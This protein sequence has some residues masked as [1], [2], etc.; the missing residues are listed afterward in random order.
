MDGGEMEKKA[1][2]FE[3]VR[4]V[5]C[6]EIKR[7][8]AKR[9]AG[10]SGET[11][12]NLYGLAL[13]GGGIRSASFAMG[14]LQ[15]LNAEGALRKIDY[16][17][18]VSGGGYAGS[19]LTW[20]LHRIDPG[21]FPF[22]QKGSGAVSH[23]RENDILGFVRQHGDYLRP[24]KGLDSIS[25]LAV[26]MR[27]S[28]LSLLVYFPL[29]CVLMSLF[30]AWELFEPLKN[31]E[32]LKLIDTW[33]KGI[34]VLKHLAGMGFNALLLVAAAVF[35]GALLIAKAFQHATRLDGDAV[36]CEEPPVK[37]RS[38]K[39]FLYVFVFFTI[40]SMATVNIFLSP[41]KG[42]LWDENF[43]LWFA[44]LLMG[45]FLMMSCIYSLMT[46]VSTIVS[47]YFR[48]V[49]ALRSYLFRLSFQRSMGLVLLLAIV[50][51]VIGLMPDIDGM[52]KKELAA[53]AV[54]GPSAMLGI[55]GAFFRFL[56]EQKSRTG[57]EGLIQKAMVPV[58]FVLMCYGFLQLAFMVSEWATVVRPDGSLDIEH[59]GVIL[60]LGAASLIMGFVVNLNYVSI[61]RMYRD[62][63]A[64]TFLPDKDTV[65]FERC[66]DMQEWRPA[67][68]ANTARLSKMCDA[69]DHGPYHLIN[70]NIVL[71]DS[72]KPVYRGRGGD[73]FLLSPKFCGSGATKWCRTE[74]FM[75]D[76]MTLATAM[77]ISGA[78][79]NPHTGVAGKGPTRSRTASFI[80]TMLNLSLGFW[81]VNPSSR[82]PF[83]VPNYFFPGLK[84][85][86]GFGYDESDV[87]IQLT[88]GG[89]FDNTG[90]YELIR[91]RAK[92]IIIS[93]GSADEECNFED[94]ANA[95]ERARV[96]FGVHIK[97]SRSETDLSHMLH[98][99]KS[100]DE[101]SRKYKLAER[102][103]A[104]GTI[105]YPATATERA[106]MGNILYVK[107]ILTKGLTADIYGYKSAHPSFPDQPTSDQFFDEA[108]FEAYR[109]LGYQL[110]MQMLLYD[111]AHDQLLA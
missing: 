62:R 41:E 103:F 17:S 99:P 78:A 27:T 89:H 86:L 75:S 12:E 18:T 110:G 22:G 79:V 95:V 82:W 53:L 31:V 106:F 51:L 91:R 50:A 88:D 32:W 28:F 29:L 105:K 35:V 36:P 85:L 65:S 14:I 84:S 20:F 71:V 48:K 63:L 102:G 46:I 30:H 64:E 52:F 55:A 104:I 69:D 73:S 42:R 92:V 76:R 97:F 5:E 24:G 7:Q 109:E 59:Y 37:K 26:L 15:A 98:D 11:C 70:T 45:G 93:D 67:T 10:A 21:G 57:K 9:G 8:R 94:L 100:K 33:L 38:A 80:M 72:G 34:P 6:E 108:Q 3:E 96:D 77:A 87:L 101:F 49:E 56:K 39:Q 83:M 1:S 13:S 19:A 2:D 25:L 74:D 23:G 58:A 54:A 68:E 61:H 107:T 90:L 66:N 4:K 60:G 111:A 16:L 81:A 43:F 47:T 40:C 44:L